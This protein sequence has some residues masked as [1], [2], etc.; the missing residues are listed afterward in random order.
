[1]TQGKPEE[2]CGDFGGVNSQGEPCGRGSGWGTPNDSGRCRGCLGT[3]PDGT[4]GENH[5]QGDQ[6]GNQNAMKTGLES[7]PVNLF[8]WCVENEPKALTYILSKLYDYSKRAPE[9]VFHADFDTDG[10]ESFEDVE[11]QLTS[12]GDDLVMMC[13]R[14]YARW[15]AAKEQLQEGITV[16][17]TRSGENGT[18]TVTAGNPVNLELDRMDKTTLRQKDTLGLMPSPDM[19]TANA[20]ESLAQV[21]SEGS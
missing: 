4:T 12:Y 17:Q 7:D 6:D 2:T 18:F 11:V 16:Q 8:N 19:K 3:K 10:V 20:A 21:L 13:I 1:M 9:A 5:G 14:D 15:R